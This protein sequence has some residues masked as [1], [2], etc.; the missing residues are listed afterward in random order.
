ME[1]LQALLA[2]I[3]ISGPWFWATVVGAPLLLFGVVFSYWEARRSQHL[4]LQ[5]KTKDQIETLREMRNRKYA[6]AKAALDEAKEKIDL[7]KF[8]VI[9]MIHDLGDWVLGRDWAPTE[10]GY[11]EAFEH[12]SQIE[13]APDSVNIIVLLHTLGGYA[14]PSHAIASALRARSKRLEKSGEKHHGKV[15]AYVPYV[16]MSGGTIVAL[17]ADEIVMGPTASLGMIDAQ[18]MFS[19]ESFKRLREDKAPGEISDFYYL[20]ANEALKYE[21]H[22]NAACRKTLNPAHAKK[23]GVDV[24][25]E[26]SDGSRPHSETV[27]IEQAKAWGI[28]AARDF[29]EKVGGEKS[30][31]RKA[32]RKWIDARIR[33]I[34]T[35]LEWEEKQLLREAG[36]KG[37]D[38]DGGQ[39]GEGG[40]PE[41]EGGLQRAAKIMM[42]RFRTGLR[43]RLRP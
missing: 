14:M 37:V 9:D 30:K 10:I 27:D 12:V 18:L 21:N 7:E 25:A 2:E 26:L 40:D 23:E 28:K 11:E 33:M 31:L 15:Y 17:A 13:Q 43:A 34:N 35:R 22:A 20:L 8:L 32:L 36:V 4:K 38:E 6:E 39:G 29:P 41:D 16:A 5:K 19:I 42:R 3:G 1:G 24:I